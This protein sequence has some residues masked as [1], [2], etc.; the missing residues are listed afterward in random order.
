M[1]TSIFVLNPKL[2]RSSKTS[3]ALSRSAKCIESFLKDYGMVDPWH[4]KNPSTH[5][6]SF[7]SPVHQSYSRIDY[8]LLDQ[9]LLP[10]VKHCEYEAIVISDFAPH[11]LQLAFQHK[12]TAASW[13]VNNLLLSDAFVKFMSIQ[14]EFV[15]VCVYN[16]NG[17]VSKGTF[18]EALNAEGK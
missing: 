1:M 17:E 2:D 3:K 4:F 14:I 10:Q 12:S 7:F 9:K 5:H 13:R 18:G 15:S 8:F 16:D 6:V 11:L